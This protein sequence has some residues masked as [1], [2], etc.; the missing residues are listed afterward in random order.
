MLQVWTP[1]SPVPRMWLLYWVI[2]FFQFKFS[3]VGRGKVV[4]WNPGCLVVRVQRLWESVFSVLPQLSSPAANETQM[5]FVN[6][7]GVKLPQCLALKRTTYSLL[8]LA[9]NKTSYWFEAA[10]FT[11]FLIPSVH[12]VLTP[13]QKLLL[14]LCLLTKCTLIQP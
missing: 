14:L 2:F 11:V 1:L 9:F 8:T 13:K 5:C 12:S 4:K 10:A 3:H 7:P 6:W